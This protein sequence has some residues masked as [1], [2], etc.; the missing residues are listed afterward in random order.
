M[1]TSFYFSAGAILISI[2]SLIWSIHIGKRDRAELKATSTFYDSGS[3]EHGGPFLKV[4]AVNH[5]R[6]P[7]ILT[8]LCSKSSSGDAWCTY[9]DQPVRLGEKDEHGFKVEAYDTC[10]ISPRDGKEAVDLWFEDTLGRHYR[11]KNAKQHLKKLKELLSRAK[12]N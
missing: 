3:R 4:K 10:T 9:L 11:I 12:K 1:E 7:I 5:G 6:R 2:T 8:A